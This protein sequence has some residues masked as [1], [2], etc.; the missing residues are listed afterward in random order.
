MSRLITGR[1]FLIVLFFCTVLSACY[2][3]IKTGYRKGTLLMNFCTV[4]RLQSNS[5]WELTVLLIK[6]LLYMSQSQTCILHVITGRKMYLLWWKYLLTPLKKNLLSPVRIWFTPVKF[7]TFL[8]TP[9]KT[10]FPRPN[11]GEI[12]N[13]TGPLRQGV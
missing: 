3:K 8:S 11:P 4:I 10:F 6:V 7:S 9:V 2:Q 1:A 13:S 12:E 5:L